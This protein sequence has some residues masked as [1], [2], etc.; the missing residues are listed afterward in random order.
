MDP[1]NFGEEKTLKF[2]LEYI[3]SLAL[4]ETNFFIFIFFATEKMLV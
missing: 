3:Y 1:K 2:G 4:S